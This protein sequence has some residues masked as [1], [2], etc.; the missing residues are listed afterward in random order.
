MI[1]LILASLFDPIEVN[2]PELDW[3]EGIDEEGR[4][5]GGG[6]EKSAIGKETC[7]PLVGDGGMPKGKALEP[8]AS[9]DNPTEAPGCLF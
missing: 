7:S 6:L 5:F 3:E 2:P 9:F 8:F 1:C 4:K